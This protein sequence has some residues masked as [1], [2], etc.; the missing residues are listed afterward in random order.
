MRLGVSEAGPVERLRYW[1]WLW[2]NRQWWFNRPLPPAEYD[3]V[4]FTGLPG[5]GKTTFGTDYV[6]RYMRAGVRVYSNIMMRDNY[7]GQTAIPVHTWLDVMRA[8]VEA[9]ED[10]VTCM[11]YLA[12][13]NT[14]CDAYDWQST[15]RWW[16][17]MM[18]QRRHMGLGLMGDTQNLA[19]VNI[20]LRNLIGR[21]V[22]VRPTWLRRLWRRWPAFVVRDINILTSDDPKEWMPEGKVHR[23]WQYSHAF[24]GHSTWELLSAQDF[25]AL[26]SPAS[27]AEIEKLRQRAIALNKSG[28]L[29]S[30]DYDETETDGEP[31]QL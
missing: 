15:P 17:E 23:V 16:T 27:Q 20:R 31:I 4:I 19:Q 7:S 6:V 29:P 2:K 18:Q 3:T 10:G 21:V 11:I 30:F 28:I 5:F 25:G 24:H 22:E 26:D 9:L 8:S 14:M 12:E 1:G 13:I